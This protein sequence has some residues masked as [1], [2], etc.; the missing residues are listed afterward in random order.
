LPPDLRLGSPLRVALVGIGS[1]ASRAHLPALSG[2]ERTGSVVVVGV[3]DRDPARRDA[4]ISAHPGA[5]GFADNEEMLESTSPDVLVIATPPSAHLSEVAAA[6]ARD[7]QVLCE[8]PLGLSDAD[9][10]TVTELADAHPHTALATVH[11]YSHAVPW[12]WMARAAGGALRAGETFGLEVRV[13]RP[14][15]DPLS[16]GGWR[17]DPKREGGILGDHAVHYLSLLRLLDPGCRVAASQRSG[18][19]G[20][21]T[22]SLRVRLGAGGTATVDLSYAGSRRSNL[23]RLRRPAQC[24]AMEWEDDVFRV[25]HRDRPSAVRRV[26]SLSERAMVNALYRPMYGELVAGLG[27]PAWRAGATAHT[28]ASARLLAAAIGLAG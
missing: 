23:I 7:V 27:D 10:A 26:A 12:Q 13:D 1:A 9:V 24:L 22:A 11:Q 5:A 6:V 25:N 4:A 20:R 28:L 19:G 14:G 3:C 18:P 17:A 2:F 15:T 21:E 16:A 8:K